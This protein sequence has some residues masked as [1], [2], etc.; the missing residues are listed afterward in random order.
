MVLLVGSSIVTA[1]CSR[2][3]RRPQGRY[4]FYISSIKQRRNNKCEIFD[5][6]MFQLRRG[7]FI[8]L[9]IIYIIIVGRRI[10]GNAIIRT[11][12]DSSHF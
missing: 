2:F 10:G 6:Q 7:I 1:T 9:K 12:K 3:I 8:F 4:K 5:L 11:N